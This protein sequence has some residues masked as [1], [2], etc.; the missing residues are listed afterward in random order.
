MSKIDDLKTKLAKLEAST[1]FDSLL[2]KSSG[3]LS[4]KLIVALAA[5]ATLIIIGRDNQAAIINWVGILALAYL[6]VQAGHDVFSGRD[7]RITRC[8]LID[9]MAKDGL[10][11]EDL[12]ALT[13]GPATP[14]APVATAP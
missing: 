8:K 11:D 13:V 14:P 1:H 7:D 3:W 12:K 5:I 9:A 4:R 2:P 10:S 6:V